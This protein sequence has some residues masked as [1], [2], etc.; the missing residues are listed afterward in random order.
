MEE[1]EEEKR[2]TDFQKVTS[3]VFKNS[4]E[5]LLRAIEEKASN[6]PEN[7]E[8]GKHNISSELQAT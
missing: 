6:S 7:A 4:V 2:E 8:A 5:A 3:V 1:Q